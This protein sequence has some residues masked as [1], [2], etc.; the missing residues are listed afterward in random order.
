[1]GCAGGSC[2]SHSGCAGGPCCLGGG[3]SCGCGQ[4]ENCPGGDL[5]DAAKHAKK[6]LLREKIKER[7]EAKIGKKLDK[8]ADMAV[9]MYIGQWEMEKQAEEKMDVMTAKLGG[10]LHG[11]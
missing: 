2:H 1:M 6:A 7:L 8:L 9:E 10:I 4:D 3:C 5:I 11:Y